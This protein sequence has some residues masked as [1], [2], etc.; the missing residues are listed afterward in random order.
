M[1]SFFRLSL[2]SFLLLF[3]SGHFVLVFSRC[4]R[5]LLISFH[6]GVE[7]LPGLIED[8]D[9]SEIEDMMRAAQ[10]SLGVLL[11][12]IEKEEERVCY[13]KVGR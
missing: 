10:S 6:H 4:L 13:V 11:E 12:K 2:A 9:L 1:S 7:T 5:D 8:E 3:P